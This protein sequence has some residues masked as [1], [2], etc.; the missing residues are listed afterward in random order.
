M[1]RGSTMNRRYSICVVVLLTS[2]VCACA[3]LTT[4][5]GYPGPEL[6]VDKVSIVELDS[7]VG[8][9]RI[10]GHEVVNVPFLKKRIAVLPG[11]HEIE[12]FVAVPVG[13][14]TVKTASVTLSFDAAAGRVYRVASGKV[15]AL[16]RGSGTETMV[17]WNKPP[18]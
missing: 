1:K 12:V 9:A 3:P 15:V 6:P 16:Y 8:M 17:L 10:D 4:Y 11:K 5:Q 7:Q 18:S 13:A 2:M 14:A